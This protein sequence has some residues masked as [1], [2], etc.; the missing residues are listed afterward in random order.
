VGAIVGGVIGGVVVI[1]G[2]AVG[3][4]F[5]RKLDKQR[6]LFLRGVPLGDEDKPSIKMVQMR[7]EK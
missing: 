5:L 7:A 1:A 2:L 6:K 3:A 4:F